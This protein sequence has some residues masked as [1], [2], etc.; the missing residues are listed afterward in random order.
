M[1]TLAVDG[2]PGDMIRANA[3]IGGVKWG[4]RQSQARPVP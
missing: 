1:R 3:T 2:L 4:C